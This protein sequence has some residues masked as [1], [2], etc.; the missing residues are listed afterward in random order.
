MA[1]TNTN[2][3]GG[4][5]S[6]G[7]SIAATEIAY[8]SATD[9]ITGDSNATRVIGS[10]TNIADSFGAG[11]TSAIQLNNNFLGFGISGA[12]LSQTTSGGS[13]L[14]GTGDFSGIGNSPI[15]AAM[16]S[17][18][19]NDHDAI[20]T[21]D[22]TSS[23][24]G[25]MM[26]YNDSSTKNPSLSLTSNSANLVYNNGVTASGF[27][28]RS[29]QLQLVNNG[30]IWDWPTSDSSG[31]QALVSDGSG[32]LSWQTIPSEGVTGSGTAGQVSY[33]DSASDITSDANFTWDN[34]TNTFTVGDPANNNLMVNGLGGITANI[35]NNAPFE[36]VS[37]SAIFAANFISGHSTI[38]YGNIAD[39]ALGTIVSLDD[40]LETITNNSVTSLWSWDG[41]NVASLDASNFTFNTGDLNGINHKTL[42]IVDDPGSQILA[43]A[44]LGF[45][46]QDTSG[47]IIADWQPGINDPSFE[48][49][50]IS[51]LSNGL[52]MTL[53]NSSSL[54]ELVTEYNSS[55]DSNVFLSRYTPNGSVGKTQI[56]DLSSV[57]H[58]IT[59]VLDDV[60]QRITSH[61]TIVESSIDSTTYGGTLNYTSG[62][63]GKARAYFSGSHS[64]TSSGVLLPTGTNAIIGTK[65]TID[66]LGGLATTDP[67]TIDAGT[68]NTI[69]STS[70]TSQTFI[71][72]ANGESVSIIKLTSTQWMIE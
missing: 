22:G 21:V 61:G 31:T 63:A 28:A 41:N 51:N 8:G 1:R 34:S 42:F 25:I 26:N 20:F 33:W 4:G 36:V 18:I 17:F 53:S 9:T 39:G 13:S 14:I 59:W 27:S 44:A 56:G 5:G 64:G 48:M 50:D 67:I 40:S 29:N 46:V 10:L 37:G 57:N 11:Q 52:R 19:S 66:D 30:N 38:S 2:I 15:T 71:L 72:N 45:F 68:T 49:G 23:S 43:K 70:G 32:N 3:G 6:I 69:T 47:N 35:G 55:F 16:I 65:F 54:V 12:G 24:G 60:L 58:G 7:G 62:F